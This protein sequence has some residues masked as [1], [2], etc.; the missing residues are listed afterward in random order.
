MDV[1]CAAAPATTADRDR[2]LLVDDQPLLRQVLRQEL[3]QA[4]PEVLTKPF[5]MT[6]LQVARRGAANRR[7]QA[8]PP[9]ATDPHHAPAS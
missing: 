3:P 1:N 2:V 9:R 4:G 8:T 7:S 5:A 6:E